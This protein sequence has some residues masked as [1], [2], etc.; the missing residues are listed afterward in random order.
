MNELLAL[1]LIESELEVV[2]PVMD[3]N[4]GTGPK[5]DEGALGALD[6]V[7]QIVFLSYLRSRYKN[8]FTM[9]N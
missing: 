2:S 7:N 1:I 9:I 3:L 4:L 6:P 8:A 5:V